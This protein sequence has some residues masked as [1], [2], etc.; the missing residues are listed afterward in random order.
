LTLNSPTHLG[1]PILICGSGIAGC[2]L[3]LHVARAGGTVQIVTKDR[4]GAGSTRRAQGGIA[5]AIA[6]G[7]SVAA[8]VRDTLEAG[9]G[10]CDP[11]AV[12]AV[13]A[14]GPACVAELSGM[15]VRFDGDGGRPALGLE[16]AHSAPRIVHAGG[17]ATGHNVVEALIAAVRAHPLIRIAEGETAIEILVRDGRASGLRSV[18]PD[19]TERLR[20]GRAVALATGGIGTSSRA[21][22]TRSGPPPTAW[23]SRP[24]P[25]RRWWIWRWC[26]STRPPSRWA[27]APRR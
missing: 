16:G 8:H 14:Y 18:D 25:A 13:C 3:A 27:T 4:L 10:L 22:P 7:D 9:A 26:S 5:A 2:L 15:G 12:R 20:H 1:D 11:E 6:A 19:G 24:V 17:D 21:P 23:P